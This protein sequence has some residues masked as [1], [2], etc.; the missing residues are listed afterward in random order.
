[1]NEVADRKV[2]MSPELME[3]WATRDAEGR[4]LSWSWGEPDEEGFYT[5]WVT[6]HEDDRLGD[7]DAAWAEAEAAL[8]EGAWLD[9]VSQSR[10][11]GQPETPLGDWIAA[12][13]RTIAPDR[14]ERWVAAGLTPAAALRALVEEMR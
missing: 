1:M 14:W 13:Q 2:R 8:P 12:A 5:P 10:I 11:M 9:A 4:R 3:R 7:L 6:A